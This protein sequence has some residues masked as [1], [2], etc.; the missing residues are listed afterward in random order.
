MAEMR[1]AAKCYILEPMMIQG[2]LIRNLS[3]PWY[4]GYPDMDST[5]RIPL[6]SVSFVICLMIILFM[7]NLSGILPFVVVA[8]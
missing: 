7:L 4:N 8:D 2:D 3:C 1:I 5:L 6:C